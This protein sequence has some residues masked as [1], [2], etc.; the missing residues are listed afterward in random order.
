MIPRYR[1]RLKPE[2]CL[3]SH[4]NFCLQTSNAMDFKDK[5]I[6]SANS[7]RLQYFNDTRCKFYFLEKRFVRIWSKLLAEEKGFDY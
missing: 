7:D 3:T 1:L 6:L 2:I 5:I 4:N